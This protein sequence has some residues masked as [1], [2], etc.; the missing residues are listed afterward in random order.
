M[1][2]S[3]LSGDAVDALN[4]ILAH[5]AEG[6]GVVGIHH[7]GSA[8]SVSYSYGHPIRWAISMDQSLEAAVVDTAREA[9]LV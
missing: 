3:Q 7:L 5:A 4:R 8:W 1:S 9:G 6:G 2:D